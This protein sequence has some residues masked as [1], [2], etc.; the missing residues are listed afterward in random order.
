MADCTLDVTDREAR[1]REWRSLRG[2]ALISER[3]STDGSVSVFENGAR[4]KR[5]LEALIEAENDCCSHLRFS[6][7]EDDERIAVEI[8]S[9]AR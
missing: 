9:A 4:V 8:T 1:M 7:S 3:H 6:L 5:R 2:E